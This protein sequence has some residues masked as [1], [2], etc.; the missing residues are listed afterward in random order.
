[1]LISKPLIFSI[2]ICS[3]IA[4]GVFSYYKGYNT[5][6]SEYKATLNQL[7]T[8]NLKAILNQERTYKE[9]ENE[10]IKDY[11]EKMDLLKQQYEKVLIVS[12]NLRDTFV[13][14][15]LQHTDTSST[16]VSKETKP[17][18]NTRCYTETDLLRK[19]KESMVIGNECDQLAI[20]YNSLLEWCKQ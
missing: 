14:D 7:Q 10:I 3:Y 8:S 17:K 20:R 4:V 16:R 5:A 6:D 18:S 19:V 1:M 11:S 9:K 13:P 2:G 12:D 15:C